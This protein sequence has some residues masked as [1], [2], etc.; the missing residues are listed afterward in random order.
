MLVGRACRRG[1]CFRHLIV[2]LP[3]ALTA[4]W[5]REDSFVSVAAASTRWSCSVPAEAFG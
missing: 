4:M 1:T 2:P 5:D 3:A